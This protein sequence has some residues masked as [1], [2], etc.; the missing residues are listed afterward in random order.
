VGEGL[1][2]FQTIA[3]P[4]LDRL[5]SKSN[6]RSAAIISSVVDDVLERRQARRNAA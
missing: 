5:G 4:A 3:A 6:R 1:A 2:A